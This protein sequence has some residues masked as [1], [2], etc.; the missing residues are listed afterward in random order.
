MDEALS[1]TF[2]LKEVE[3]SGIKQLL[4]QLKMKHDEI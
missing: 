4:V 1:I 3:P 2:T